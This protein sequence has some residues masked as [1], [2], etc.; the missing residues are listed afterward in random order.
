MVQRSL[1]TIL[2]AFGGILVLLGGVLGL[3]LGYGRYDYGLRYG[4]VDVAVIA[5]LA[6]IF[7]L[8]ILVYSGVTHLRGPERS[9]IGGVVLVVLGIVAWAVS[10]ELFLVGLGSF[11]TILAGVILF[12]VMMIEEPRHPTQIA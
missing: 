8:V 6:I 5:V 11:L 10:G 4:A 7:G 12:V 2:A 1:V 9:L 3:L